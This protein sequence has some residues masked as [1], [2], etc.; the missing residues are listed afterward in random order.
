MQCLARQQLECFYS[1]QNRCR[2]RCINNR[3]KGVFDMYPNATL[4]ACEKKKASECNYVAMTSCYFSENIPGCSVVS[5]SVRDGWPGSCNCICK[6]C[7][8]K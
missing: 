5:W 1:E 2:K 6:H 8:Y 7:L 3:Y 4:Q